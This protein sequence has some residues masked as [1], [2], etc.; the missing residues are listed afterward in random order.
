MHSVSTTGGGKAVESGNAVLSLLNIH[1]RNLNVKKNN[2][3]F[4]TG[5]PIKNNDTLYS[6]YARRRDLA[7]LPIISRFGTSVYRLCTT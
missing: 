4:K 7:I 1:R 6:R 2:K 5:T 3:S